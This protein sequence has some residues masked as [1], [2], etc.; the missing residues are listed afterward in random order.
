[1][2]IINSRMKEES[3]WA[4][5]AMMDTFSISKCHSRNEEKIH[6]YSDIDWLIAVNNDTAFG[7]TLRWE[8]SCFPLNQAALLIKPQ[9]FSSSYK[10]R[11]NL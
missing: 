5:F 4:V 7:K 11:P 6:N 10:Q 8:N 9:G 2:E 1:M 3:A